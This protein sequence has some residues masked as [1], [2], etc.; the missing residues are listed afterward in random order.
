MKQR[1]TKKQK[2]DL[3]AVGAMAAMLNG[4]LKTLDEYSTTRS[5]QGGQQIGAHRLDINKLHNEIIAGTT[6]KDVS[7]ELINET[8]IDDTLSRTMPG[9]TTGVEDEARALMAEQRARETVQVSPSERA[10]PMPEP[11]IAAPTPSEKLT[12]NDLMRKARELEQLQASLASQTHEIVEPSNQLEFDLKF[13]QRDALF[14]QLNRIEDMMRYVVSHLKENKY[15]L[16]RTARNSSKVQTTSRSA[17]DGVV[18]ESTKTRSGEHPIKTKS[19]K[20]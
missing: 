19:A 12:H 13:D 16:K 6:H 9:V 2:D 1:I 14:D 8:N 4:E 5:S 3:D 10:V 18:P 20:G 7:Q 17:T 15:E 11:V